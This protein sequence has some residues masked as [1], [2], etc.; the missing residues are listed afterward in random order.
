MAIQQV[1]SLRIHFTDELFNVDESKITREM[2]VHETV[3]NLTKLDM[4]PEAIST[5]NDGAL[6]DI[7]DELADE[8]DGVIQAR[9]FVTNPLYFTDEFELGTEYLGVHT[10]H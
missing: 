1:L 3:I 6:E 9:F 2:K 7:S 10:L 8:I 4:R 5:E